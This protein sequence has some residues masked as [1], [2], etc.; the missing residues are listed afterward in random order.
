MKHAAEFLSEARPGVSQ[1]AYTD[2]LTWAGL[3]AAIV[4]LPR[5][6]KAER[7]GPNNPEQWSVNT[8]GR[9]AALGKEIGQAASGSPFK[10]V[11][12]GEAQAVLATS[13]FL[14]S[15]LKFH[16]WFAARLEKV[17]TEGY[18]LPNAQVGLAVFSTSKKFEYL[19]VRLPY[20]ICS[21]CG[22]PTKDYGGKKHI[23]GND[24][25]TLMSD[26]WSDVA[27]PPVGM[28]E[29][30]RS[31]VVDL[32]STSNV[33]QIGIVDASQVDRLPSSLSAAQVE[34][35]L[36]KV[37]LANGPI[38]PTLKV[39]PSGIVIGDSL[40]AL[41][42]IEDKSVDL[43]FLDPPYNLAKPYASYQ[44]DL[45]VEEYFEWCDRWL[46]ECV[47]VL[48]VGGSLVII[49][50]PLGVMR[51]A[52]YLNQRLRF[53]NWIAWDALSSPR[54]YIMPAHYPLLWYSKGQ[55]ASL[56]LTREGPEA[57]YLKSRQVGL[58]AR[59]SCIR[60]RGEQFGDQPLSDLWTDIF[61]VLHN[62]QRLDHPCILPPKAMKRV[63]A[64]GSKPGEVVLDPFNGVGTTTV[65]AHQMGR[66]YLGIEMEP[67]YAEAAVARHQTVE[68]GGDPFAK[69]SARQ[70][71]AKTA[72][73]KKA[74][75][76][77]VVEVAKRLGHTPS[78][79]ELA[80][81]AKYPIEVFEIAFRSWYEVTAGA[82]KAGYKTQAS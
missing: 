51:H 42:A 74:L 31:R 39:N 71:Q 60:A 38:K 78:R 33:H 2:T 10:L 75:Q 37:K 45:S 20:G 52:L 72:V 73:S 77:E 68:N 54:G 46:E 79:E 41:A 9:L 29:E 23:R 34:A 47:R 19:K 32:L 21:A 28:D 13:A 66:G 17:Q 14:G 80:S 64:L 59:A 4:L 63:V 6:A 69:D 12:V 22:K 11:L 44:D 58:C 18:W 48:K 3:D 26:V 5:L 81:Y 8:L 62:S 24:F 35:V 65:S 55:A 43:V 50:I 57:G 49:N 82:K 67:A 27:M 25:G 61:R 40:A 53:Q 1:V 16:H 15:G 36:P 56:H 30:T 70:R 76:L 7:Q